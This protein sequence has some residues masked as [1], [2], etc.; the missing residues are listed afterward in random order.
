MMMT[1][2]T[3]VLILVMTITSSMEW[4]SLIPEVEAPCVPPQLAILATSIVQ[5]VEHLTGSL[6]PIAPQAITVIP[7]QTV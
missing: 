7:V 3:L 6:P 5:H 1:P 4:A 2:I